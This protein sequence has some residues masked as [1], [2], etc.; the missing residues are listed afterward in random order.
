MGEGAWRGRPPPGAVALCVFLFPEH[1]SRARGP[2][3]PGV[4]RSGARGASVACPVCPRVGL[5][6][7]ALGPWQD[8]RIRRVGTGMVGFLLQRIGY[9]LAVLFAV[10]SL[11]FG[12][13]HLSGDPLAA[14]VPPGS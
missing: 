13:I 7:V 5:P 6:M 3:A 11:V 9:G 12:L 1:A 2:F 4:F 10:T 14:L 8:R